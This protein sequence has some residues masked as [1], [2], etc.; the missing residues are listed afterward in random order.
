MIL[1]Y[2]CRPIGRSAKTLVISG[3]DLQIAAFDETTVERL[4]QDA[5][6]HREVQITSALAGPA[7]ASL[8]V[9]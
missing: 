7:C 6:A 1:P 3:D 5:Q 4:I 8:L 2:V 9:V